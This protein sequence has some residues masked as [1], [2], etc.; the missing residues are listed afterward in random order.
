[1]SYISN[2]ILVNSS[3]SDIGYLYIICFNFI[4]CLFMALVGT[5]SIINQQNFTQR[6]LIFIS[7]AN[8]SKKVFIIILFRFGQRVIFF[9][10]RFHFVKT[11]ICI[12]LGLLCLTVF[13]TSMSDVQCQNRWNIGR[14]EIGHRCLQFAP[15][16]MCINFDQYIKRFPDNCLFQLQTLL[17]TCDQRVIA[18]RFFCSTG[19]FSYQNI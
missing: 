1:M 16:E 12:R 8:K 13:S 19:L 4:I 6:V 2:S 14:P 17:I 15:S 3:K 9:R 10:S 18:D 7:K 11:L 5:H